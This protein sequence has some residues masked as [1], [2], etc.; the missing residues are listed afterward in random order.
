MRRLSVKLNQVNFVESKFGSA[1][2][3]NKMDN[4]PRNK[5]SFLMVSALYK[6]ERAKEVSVV[7]SGHV[8]Q[9]ILCTRTPLRAW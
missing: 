8:V 7:E 1:T 2:L 6:K 5:P 3:Y 4:S 9:E